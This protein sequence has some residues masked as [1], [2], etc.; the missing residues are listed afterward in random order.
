ML[1]RLASPGEAEKLT[2]ADMKSRYW[3]LAAPPHPLPVPE[4]GARS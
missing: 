2:V 3:R 1:N 4:L